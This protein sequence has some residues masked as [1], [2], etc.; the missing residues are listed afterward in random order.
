MVVY[1]ILLQEVSFNYRAGD[2]HFFFPKIIYFLSR[3][4][5]LFYH[6]ESINKTEPHLCPS[7]SSSS[8][9]DTG[10]YFA[11]YFFLFAAA[12]C[13]RFG[14]FPLVIQKLNPTECKRGDADDDDNRRTSG[15]DG[16]SGGHPRTPWAVYILYM[17]LPEDTLKLAK[18]RKNSTVMKMMWMIIVFQVLCLGISAWRFW[19]SGSMSLLG[20]QTR[21]HV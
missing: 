3:S 11:I 2:S 19:E 21:R 20:K 16:G 4:F 1:K 8:S 7:S 9:Y 17:Y 15:A 13:V 5:S 14:Y 6:L 10:F 18:S 12:F